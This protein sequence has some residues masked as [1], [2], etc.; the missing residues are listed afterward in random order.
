MFG[1]KKQP[2]LS[3]DTLPI[4][5]HSVRSMEAFAAA[6]KLWNVNARNVISDPQSKKE[7]LHFS[8]VN[9]R[10]VMWFQR[11]AGRSDAFELIISW[12]QDK[13][14]LTDIHV[15]LPGPEKVGDDTY[16]RKV[17]EGLLTTASTVPITQG[18]K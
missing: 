4:T 11:D 10:T 14:V 18:A 8:L 17:L 12:Q 3:A 16:V 5:V 7:V 9:P 6:Q 13:A 1:S 2:Q 15:I